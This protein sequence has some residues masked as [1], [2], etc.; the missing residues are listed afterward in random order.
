MPRRDPEERSKYQRDYY[1]RNSERLRAYQVRYRSENDE[2]VAEKKRE[3]AKEHGD[4]IQTSVRRRYQEK[5]ARIREFKA[6]GCRECGVLD[7]RVLTLHHRD[8][9]EKNPRL[10]GPKR[11]SITALSWADLEV[12]LTKCDVLCANCHLIETWHE[13]S[14]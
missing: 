1:E 6:C 8:A 12:E 10:R 4:K 3:Y 7:V 14:S 2:L 9:E 5:Q 13:E 11:I